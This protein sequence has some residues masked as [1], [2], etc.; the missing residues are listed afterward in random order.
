LQLA[1]DD[2]L[3]QSLAAPIVK[4]D[5][6]ERLQAALLWLWL[7]LQRRQLDPKRQ[8]ILSQRLKEVCLGTRHLIGLPEF[9]PNT[10]QEWLRTVQNLRLGA[11]RLSELQI[12]MFPSPQISR[13]EQ[14]YL[15]DLYGAA[16]PQ[17]F[18][19]SHLSHLRMSLIRTS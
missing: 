6:I 19:W 4:A 7:G 15:L 17:R 1:A 2:C 14:A 16:V 9:D 11:L 3:V 12:P 18:H 5:F 13:D 10:N 8:H